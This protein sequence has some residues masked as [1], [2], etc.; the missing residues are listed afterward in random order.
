MKKVLALMLAIA[1]VFCFAACGQTADEQGEDAGDTGVTSLTIEDLDNAPFPVSYTY[2]TSDE[3]GVIDSGEYEYPE[4]IDHSLL[5]PTHATMID[6][7]IIDSSIQ[8]GMIYTD[9]NATLQDDTVVEIL[10][11]NDPDT[12]EYVAASVI[13]ETETTLYTFA[14]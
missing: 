10:Y 6:R 8:D 11:I 14:Y 4:D 9:V 7:E 12:L 1:M 5:I 2:E 13:T 3:S